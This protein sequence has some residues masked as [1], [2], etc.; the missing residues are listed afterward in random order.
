MILESKIDVFYD[1]C[2]Y[3]D[4]IISN[5][6]GPAH[7]AGLTNRD[8]IWLA[9]DNEVSRSCYPLG[10]KVHKILSKNVKD[11]ETKDVLKKIDQII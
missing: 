8:L 2:L 10:N 5:D 4:L 1:L 9:N 11:V 3:A 7:I 6:T